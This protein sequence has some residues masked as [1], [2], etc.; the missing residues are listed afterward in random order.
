MLMA[1]M[2]DVLI[3][4]VCTA[5]VHIGY[6]FE[7]KN[8]E[9]IL[10]MTTRCI[11]LKV[12]ASLNASY[13]MRAIATELSGGRPPGNPLY[14]LEVTYAEK[15]VQHGLSYFNLQLSNSLKKSLEVF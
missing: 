7:N 5:T 9:A 8:C 13:N 4:V 11:R 3:K 14:E 10:A 1:C 6:N 12:D 15:C 2:L